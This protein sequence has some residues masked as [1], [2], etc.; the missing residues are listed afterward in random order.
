MTYAQLLKLF[1][2]RQA[3]LLQLL[4]EKLMGL[5]ERRGCTLKNIF[6]SIEARIPST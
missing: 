1:S 4:P 5:H 3:P 2:S 6:V